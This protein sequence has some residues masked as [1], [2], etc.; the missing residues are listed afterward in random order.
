[1]GTKGIAFANEKVKELDMEDKV[2]FVVGNVLS[3]PFPDESFDFVF[4]NGVI[5][6][7]VSTEKG[8]E[9]V[10]RVLKE[11]GS[12]FVYVQGKGGYQWSITDASRE[13]LKPVPKEITQQV[14]VLNGIP[15]NRVFYMMDHLYVPIQD[16]QSKEDFES[17]L[18]KHN[19]NEF[20]RLLRGVKFDGIE[21]ISNSE[22]F[23]VEKYGTSELRYLAKK[24]SK[25]A[26]VD[27]SYTN[28]KWQNHFKTK[29]FVPFIYDRLLSYSL[30]THRQYNNNPYKY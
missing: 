10:S 28:R 6:H 17:M 20:H 3:I 27:K 29:G 23:A 8:L 26:A 24:T 4:S 9:E 15:H 16:W 2:Q 18:K 25:T 19:L 22:P 21:K 13:I 30:T 1:M 7:S 11:G 14:M 12:T 5:H